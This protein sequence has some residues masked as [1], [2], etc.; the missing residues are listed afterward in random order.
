[1]GLTNLNISSYRYERKFF[2]DYFSKSKVQSIIELHPEMF[3]KSFHQRFVNNIYFDSFQMNNYFDNV[4]GVRDRKK[5]RVRWYGSLW[6][7]IEKPI[8]EIKIKKGLLGKKIS[9]PL[10][11]FSLNQET[12]IMDILNPIKYFKENIPFKPETLIPTLLNRYSREYFLSSNTNYRITI[13]NDQSFYSINKEKNTFL[14]NYQDKK[15]VVVELKYNKKFDNEAHS[16]TSKLP[17]RMT[18]SSKYIYGLE[19]I[20]N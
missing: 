17:F 10:N 15:S 6:C 20:I 11:S 3:I 14:R 7:L 4:E 16:I 8:L 2:I 18:K 12:K 13:D 5:I 9:Y 19:Q 1:M